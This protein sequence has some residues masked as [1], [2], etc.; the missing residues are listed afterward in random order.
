MKTTK[1]LEALMLELN[2]QTLIAEAAKAKIEELRAQVL[3][4]LTASGN[5]KV[6][7]I[8]GKAVVVESKEFDFTEFPQVAEA[9][10]LA[11]QTKKDA[12]EIAPFTVKRGLRFTPNRGFEAPAPKTKKVW[13]TRIL[14]QAA[15]TR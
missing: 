15:K 13:N 2:Q 9:K 1:T 4:E 8:T 10:A 14:I 7:T 11:D 6:E 12:Q 5:N 3:D